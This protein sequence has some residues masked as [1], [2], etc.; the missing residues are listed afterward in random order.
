MFLNTLTDFEV[1]GLKSGYCLA[2]GHAYQDL[3]PSFQKIVQSLPDIWFDSANKTI[4]EAEKKFNQDYANFINSPILSNYPN[5]RICPT[6]SNSIDLIAAVLKH[7]KLN[8]V[9]IEPTFDNLALLVRRRGVQLESIKDEDLFNAA[10]IDEIDE[11]FPGLKNFGAIF[12]VNPNNPTGIELTER[13]FRNIISFCKKHNIILVI[14][15]CFRVYRKNTFDDYQ[16]LIDSNVSFMT[17]EDTGKVWPTQDL[18][19]SLTYF[20]EDLA[21]IYNEIYNE[22]YLCVSNFSLGVIASFINET[23]KIGIENTIL[24]LV[25]IRR[26]RVRQ[27]IDGSIFAIP[28]VSLNSNLPVEWLVFN[29]KDKTDFDICNILKK[30]NLAILPGRQFY[31]NSSENPKHQKNV[32][33][34]LMKKE[35]IFS[36]GINILKQY[37][38]DSGF[39]LQ[40]TNLAMEILESSDNS[41]SEVLLPAT[42]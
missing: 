3:H 17:L 27:I 31:W 19:A 7:L 15:N 1:A 25:N 36:S 16:I 29:D 37:I 40:S 30:Y 42:C 23:A 24:S 9:L 39:N 11:K 18:K 12:L 8:A 13:A 10:N 21:R 28:E 4:P 38:L 35:R 20:S 34:S 2:D 14:D 41:S 26:L 6:A 22:V 5:F 33:V 32:R